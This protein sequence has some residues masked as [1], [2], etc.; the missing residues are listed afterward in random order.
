[1]YMYLLTGIYMY[2]HTYWLHIRTYWQVQVYTVIIVGKFGSTNFGESLTKTYWQ[3]VNLVRRTYA[4]CTII[5]RAHVLN[6]GE[7]LIWQFPINLPNHQIKTLAKF[8]RYTVHIYLLTDTGTG[9]YIPTDGV[10]MSL[11]C[12]CW[13]Q[14]TSTGEVGA[15]GRGDVEVRVGGLHRNHSSRSL[16]RRRNEI[17]ID[18]CI[19][20]CL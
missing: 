13:L 7:V 5:R 2:I 16:Q 19:V 6:F 14:S 8:S 1:M 11:Q 17:S 15:A 18:T 20:Y 3:I 10:V 9:I 12:V 4:H